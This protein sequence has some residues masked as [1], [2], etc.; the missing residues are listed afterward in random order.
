MTEETERAHTCC[1][2][3]WLHQLT[4]P[5]VV[6]VPYP[7]LLSRTFFPYL[8]SEFLYCEDLD[9]MLFPKTSLYLPQEELIESSRFLTALY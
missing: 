2:S 8:S 5:S 6:Y 9:Q 1:S 7:C 4:R 3:Q